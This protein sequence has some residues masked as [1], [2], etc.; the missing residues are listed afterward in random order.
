MTDAD[1]KLFKPSWSWRRHEFIGRIISFVTQDRMDARLLCSMGW[2]P[3]EDPEWNYDESHIHYLA[4]Y[5]D[6]CGKYK[7]LKEEL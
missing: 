2:H 3:W 4:R 5:C 7:V 1:Q 6:S